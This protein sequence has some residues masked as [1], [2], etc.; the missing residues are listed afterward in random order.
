MTDEEAAQLRKAFEQ[1]GATPKA[2]TPED[3]EEWMRGYLATRGKLGELKTEEKAEVVEHKE[4]QPKKESQA[5]RNYHQT[6]RI[7]PFS[8]DD[9]SKS[10]TSFDL[11]KFEVECLLKTKMHPEPVIC[12][13]VRKSLRGEAARI[14]KRQGSEATVHRILESLEAVYGEVDAGETLLAEF[15]AARQSKT[16]DVSAWGCRLEDLLDR[17]KEH[18]KMPDAE[19]DSMLR[20]RFWNGLS[21]RLKDSSRHKYDGVSN[22]DRLRREIRII[23][24]EHKMADEEDQP[25][26]VSKAQVKMTSANLD[27][28]EGQSFKELQGLVCKLSS[29]MDAMQK[30]VS[31]KGKVP[32]GKEPVME[33]TQSSK[34]SGQGQGETSMGSGTPSGTQQWGTGQGGP[35]HGAAWQRPG[36]PTGNPAQFTRPPAQYSGPRGPPGTSAPPYPAQQWNQGP[37]QD[38][39]PPQR[40]DRVCFKCKQP[41]HF[42]VDCPRRYEPTCFNC[43]EIGHRQ[44]EC[45]SLNWKRP[46]S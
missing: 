6:P 36:Q 11:W 18:K 2:D 22:F 40:P 3:L 27:T 1:I 10:D 39:G 42:K 20:S 23:E 7:S 4:G 46:L 14:A 5:T 24:K 32:T 37:S 17:A 21:P 15:Y 35:S 9:N 33:N 41:G 13:A 34:P 38:R 45:Q 44:T 30:Q 12:L 28:G 8:G 25:E 19:A 16:E 31:G 26:K 43:G 29:Q